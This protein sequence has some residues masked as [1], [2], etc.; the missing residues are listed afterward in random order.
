MLCIGLCPS[1][2]LSLCIF[3]KCAIY[4]F[5]SN[6]IISHRVLNI[7]SNVGCFTCWMPHFVVL[8]TMML[9]SH[10]R[11]NFHAQNLNE[12]TNLVQSLFF[13]IC[14][15]LVKSNIPH[16]RQMN[17]SSFQ[18]SHLAHK[19]IFTY[20]LNNNSLPTMPLYRILPIDLN[21]NQINSGE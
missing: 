19:N 8:R 4:E 13:H 21:R 2:Q 14:H 6:G 1:F 17:W 10:F 12:R 7:F 20:I 15:F 11:F 5:I 18:M 3:F 16:I 9:V